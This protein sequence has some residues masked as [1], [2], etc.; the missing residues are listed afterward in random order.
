MLKAEWNSSPLSAVQQKRFLKIAERI[1]GLKKDF[2]VSI[3][4]ISPTMM[5]RL[6]RDYRGQDRVTDVLSFPLTPTPLPLTPSPLPEGEGGMGVGE[7]LVCLP[8][9]QKQ[10]RASGCSAKE[11]TIRLLAHGLLHLFGHDHQTERAANKMFILQ[12]KIV[13]LQNYV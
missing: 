12:E 13:K 7:I 9:V 3:A 4:F 6:N 5:R 2:F 1:L 10:A 8:Q 11:E